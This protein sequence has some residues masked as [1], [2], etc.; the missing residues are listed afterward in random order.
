MAN[1]ET[2]VKAAVQHHCERLGITLETYGEAAGIDPQRFRN[3]F[4]GMATLSEPEAALLAPQLNDLTSG[5][6]WDVYDAKMRGHT[7]PKTARDVVLEMQQG[8]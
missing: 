1:P 7:P 2:S 6:D 5:E 8:K 4:N 3:W